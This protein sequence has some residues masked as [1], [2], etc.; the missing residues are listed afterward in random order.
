MREETAEELATRFIGE[1]ARVHMKLLD[2]EKELIRL[3]EENAE[4]INI[5][6]EYESEIVGRW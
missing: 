1:W 5:V 2:L 3:R 4:L 6:R